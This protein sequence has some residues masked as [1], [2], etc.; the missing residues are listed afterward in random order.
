MLRFRSVRCGFTNV[1]MAR[2]R[3]PL[4]MSANGQIF[5]S[6]PA[7]SI[8]PGW[9]SSRSTQIAAMISSSCG[10]E[11]TALLWAP[12]R[13]KS[14]IAASSANSVTTRFCPGMVEGIQS[15]DV[16]RTLAGAGIRRRKLQIWSGSS[17]LSRLSRINKTSSLASTRAIRAGT[18]PS[19][20]R[21]RSVSS[22]SAR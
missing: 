17:A 11:T 8:A 14:S 12:A 15:R 6:A 18:R 19:S 13:L 9:R 2:S 7:I 21:S 20:L 3:S 4:K 1:G 22:H 10:A 5:H 16:T